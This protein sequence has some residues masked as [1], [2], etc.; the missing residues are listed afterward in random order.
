MDKSC[1]YF[2]ENTFFESYR[3]KTKIGYSGFSEGFPTL[4]MYWKI[5]A[6]LTFHGLKSFMNES[7]GNVYM[8]FFGVFP[9]SSGELSSH[10]IFS[11]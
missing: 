3:N 9:E 8:L 6:S 11:L 4:Q 2:Y 5:K 10:K 7:T 1:T